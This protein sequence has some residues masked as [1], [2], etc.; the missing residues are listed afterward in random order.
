MI[1]Q[2]MVLHLIGVTLC[3]THDMLIVLTH[4][5]MMEILLTLLCIMSCFSP[6]GI[7]DGTGIY[8]TIFHQAYR[9]CRTGTHH[10]SLKRS[11]PLSVFMLVKANTQLFTEVVDCSN[12]TLLTYSR[13][14]D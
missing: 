12:S 13:S 8:C 4:G 9:P 2:E 6:T 14:L 3:F 10:E 11:I 7:T 5:L 1:L